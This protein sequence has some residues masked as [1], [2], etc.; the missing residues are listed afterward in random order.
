MT[1]YLNDEY[2]DRG[3]KKWGGFFLSEHTTIQTSY[4]EAKKKVNIQKPQMDQKEISEILV[5]SRIKN[6]QIAVQLEAVDIEGNYYDDV[7]GTLKGI[8][9]R[10]LYIGNQRIDFDEIR[11][12]E[13]VD[14]T[15]WSELP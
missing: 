6:R 12:V 3:I 13:L 10:G 7:V 11:N 14:H 4:E 8:D 2:R 5:Q 9:S 15:K 1:K